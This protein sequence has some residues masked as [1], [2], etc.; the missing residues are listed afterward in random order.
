M[1]KNECVRAIFDKFIDNN[2]DLEKKEAMQQN[3][4][5]PVSRSTLSSWY[6]RKAQTSDIARK[7]S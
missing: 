3:T 2:P 6:D 7:I 5:L 4:N 1:A